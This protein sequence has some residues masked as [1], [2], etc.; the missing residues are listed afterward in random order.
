MKAIDLLTRALRAVGNVGSGETPNADD[1]NTALLAL[2]DMLDSWSLS[3]L[4]VYQLLE[5]NFPLTAGKGVYSV[6]AGGDFN[7]T[8]ATTIGSAYVRLGVTDYPVEMIDNDAYSNIG[9]KASFNSIPQ[10]IYYNPSQPLGEINLWPV[11]Q[12]GLTLYMQSPKQLMQFPDLTTD[13]ILPPGYAEGVRYALLPRL[14]AE[15]LGT[16]NAEQVKLSESSVE[17]IK[18]LNSNVP[19]LKPAY[20]KGGSGRFNIFR[21]Y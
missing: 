21:G 18:T 7:T 4:F 8:R 12:A 9:L 6:G 17:R 20:R 11:P 19:V 16:V 5:E 2:N 3:K 14:A 15:G 13:I 10:Y 1:M